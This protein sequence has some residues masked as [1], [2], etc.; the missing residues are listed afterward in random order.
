MVDFNKMGLFVDGRSAMKGR[1]FRPAFL[2]SLEAPDLGS[3]MRKMTINIGTSA[4]HPLSKSQ[5]SALKGNYITLL[6]L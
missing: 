6:I 3:P 2:G 1:S 4:L 5:Y